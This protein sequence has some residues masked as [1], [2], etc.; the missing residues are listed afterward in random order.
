MVH[1]SVL[2]LVDA[3]LVLLQPNKDEGGTLKYDMR[4]IANDVEYFAF[5]R[6]QG[7]LRNSAESNQPLSAVEE[8]SPDGIKTETA[9][10]DSLWFFNG[11]RIQCWTDIQDLLKPVSLKGTRDIPQPVSIPTDFYPTSISLSNG[12]VIGIE[13]E[14]VQR[15]DA[16]FAFFRFSIRV[17]T[18]HPLSHTTLTS[19]QTQLFLPPLLH[20]Y[21]SICDSPSALNLSHHYQPLPYFPHALEI[22]LHTVLDEEVDSAPAPETALLPSVISFLSSFPG[23]LDILVQCTRKTEVRSWRTLF[24]YLP[25]PQELFEESLQKGLLKTAGGYLL[26]LHTFEELDSSSEQCVRL[27]Q[28]AKE[29]ADWDLCKE[30]ARFLMALDESGDSLREAMRRINVRTE[31]GDKSERTNGFEGGV[32]RLRAPVLKGRGSPLGSAFSREG[33]EVEGGRSP[34]SSGG[35]GGLEGGEDYFSSASH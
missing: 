29:K 5:V 3:K 1:A 27:L 21:L 23:Y 4:I 20:H 11:N 12:V 28:R 9:L 19:Q 35:D 17:G 33:S 24:K 25:P 8:N 18:I 26:I 6:D 22:L 14:L 2:F 13:P 15:R 30:L 32:A 34:G 10:Q 16:Q 7:L 31:S